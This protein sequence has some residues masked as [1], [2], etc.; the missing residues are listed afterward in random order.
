MVQKNT[1]SEIAKKHLF[2]V[3]HAETDWNDKKLCQ[4]Q[5]D[6]PLNE[7]GI[8][9]AK[10]IAEDLKDKSISCIVTSP[11]MRA[12]QTANEIKHFHLNTKLH[13]VSDLQ[14]RN[15]G[16]LEGISSEE[17]YAIEKLEEENPLYSPGRGVEQRLE[18]RKRVLKG[19]IEAQRYDPHPFVVSHGRVF[20]EL[21]YI[22]N[23][24]PIR[25][26]ANCQIIK[27]TV[28]NSSWKANPI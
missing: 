4:G 13:V 22:L 15:W 24:P 1:Q 12:M 27:L 5:E 26:L 21:C 19:F 8:R 14:E 18:F 10:A 17:M 23:I 20:M 16:E 25:Q 3:R 7:K 2:F 6:I 9:R 28:N 11:L